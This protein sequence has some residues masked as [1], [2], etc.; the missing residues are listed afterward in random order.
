M[1]AL[2]IMQKPVTV[3]WYREPWTWLVLGGPLLVVFASMYTAFLAYRGADRVVAED[4]YRQGLAINK[5]IR[6]DSAARAQKISGDMQLDR[7]TGAISFKLEGEGALPSVLLLTIS[8]APRYGNADVI[9]HVRLVQ[10]SP[11]R[12]AGAPQEKFDADVMALWH[13]KVEAPDWRLAGEWAD[14]LHAT[15]RLKAAQ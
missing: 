4:Y 8:H 12:Y 6:R 3:R 11:G 7:S 10:V 15:L 1:D 14:P 9:S 13:V 2:P 5:D